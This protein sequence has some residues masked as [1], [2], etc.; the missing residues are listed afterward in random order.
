V[1]EVLY[2]LIGKFI[3]CMQQE[4]FSHIKRK[5]QHQGDLAFLNEIQS[6]C[7]R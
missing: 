4:D 1:F 3:F 7:K 6:T 5:L 2:E